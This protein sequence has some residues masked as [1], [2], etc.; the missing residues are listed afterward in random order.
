VEVLYAAVYYFL[1]GILTILWT[2]IVG[3]A[4]LPAAFDLIYRVLLWGGIG[5]TLAWIDGWLFHQ[6]KLRYRRLLGATWGILAGALYALIEELITPQFLSWPFDYLSK[7]FLFGF[8]LGTFQNLELRNQMDVPGMIGWAFI[9][10]LSW[11]SGQLIFIACGGIV[12]ML[13]PQ[14]LDAWP[15]IFMLPPLV[16]S[17]GLMGLTIG[18]ARYQGAQRLFGLSPGRAR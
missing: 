8:A 11:I 1:F 10:G 14:H 7:G 5:A 6:R 3:Y 4:I 18:L 12:G 17:T 16:L 13:W 15:P 9:S 2:G